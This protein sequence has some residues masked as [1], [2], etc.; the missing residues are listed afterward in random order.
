MRRINLR[1]GGVGIMGVLVSLVEDR[2]AIAVPGSGLL[3]V[4]GDSFGVEAGDMVLVEG[5]GAVRLWV[6]RCCR[7]LNSGCRGSDLLACVYIVGLG[8]GW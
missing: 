7:N 5:I 8:L 1:C 3:V 4:T 6:R 2:Q